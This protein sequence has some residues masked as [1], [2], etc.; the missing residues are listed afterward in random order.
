MNIVAQAACTCVDVPLSTIQ[1]SLN[2]TVI[3]R[4]LYGIYRLICLCNVSV[5][6]FLFVYILFLCRDHRVYK[7]SSINYYLYSSVVVYY[8]LIFMSRLGPKPVGQHSRIIHVCKLSGHREIDS[9]TV[10]CAINFKFK[11]TCYV[12]FCFKVYFLGLN[13]KCFFK[14]KKYEFCKFSTALKF[15]AWVWRTLKLIM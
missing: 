9:C 6:Q 3:I 14:H 8:Y 1:I 2:Q 7:R 15:D 12:C 10:Y 13:F 11:N 5:Y 4:C